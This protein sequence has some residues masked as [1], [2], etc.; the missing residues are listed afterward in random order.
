MSILE[1]AKELGEAIASSDELKNMKNAEI[2]MMNDPEASLLVNEFNQKQRY[3]LELRDKGE[4]LTP[5]QIAEVEDLEQKVMDNDLIVN[6]FR[7]QQG[8]ERVLEEI[9]DI[10]A[11][12]ISGDISTCQSTDCGSCNSC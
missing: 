5:E 4:D 12:S 8:F 6:F 3:F 7:K 11:R 10:I 9:N 1:K 2:A